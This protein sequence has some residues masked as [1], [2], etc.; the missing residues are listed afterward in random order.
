MLITL[1]DSL[2][3]KHRFISSWGKL[4]GLVWAA[5]QAGETVAGVVER[6]VADWGELLRL[7]RVG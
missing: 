7:D 2:I 3:P 6:V 1:V 4:E 5:A